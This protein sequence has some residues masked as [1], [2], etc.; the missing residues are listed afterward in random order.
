MTLNSDLVIFPEYRRGPP[1]LDAVVQ[2]VNHLIV[3]GMVSVS[4]PFNVRIGYH[5]WSRSGGSLR[6]DLDR[7]GLPAQRDG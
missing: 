1:S 2:V 5:R 6:R 3:E 7:R 4:R